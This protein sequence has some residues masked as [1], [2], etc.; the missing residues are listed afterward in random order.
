MGSINMLSSHNVTKKGKKSVVIAEA[1]DT[2]ESLAE[3]FGLRKWEI[4]RYNKVKKGATPN[5]GDE[6]IVKI[7]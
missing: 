3:E 5:T 6:I 2:Y 7:W 1:N 4:R